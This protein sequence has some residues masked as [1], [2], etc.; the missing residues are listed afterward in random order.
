[1][2]SM[3]IVLKCFYHYDVYKSTIVTCSYVI[4]PISHKHL[5]RR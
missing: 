5:V 2:N 4:V 1:M 3:Y